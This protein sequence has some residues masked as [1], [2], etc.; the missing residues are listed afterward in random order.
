MMLRC[1]EV[2][3]RWHWCFIDVISC[4]GDNVEYYRGDIEVILR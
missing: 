2:I 4:Y 3:L 1:I